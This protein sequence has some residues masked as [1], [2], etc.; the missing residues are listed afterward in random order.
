M[1]L[2]LDFHTR[3]PAPILGCFKAQGVA[4]IARYYDGGR[5]PGKG[6]TYA[7]AQDA[8]AVGL[9]IHTVYETSG[10]ADIDGFPFGGDYF[11][12]SQGWRD[13]L[14]AVVDANSARQ[15]RGTPIFLAVD[16]HMPVDDGR[17]T[18]YFQGATDSDNHIG[19]SGFLIG[20][21]GPDYVCIHVRDTFGI[22]NLWPWL[23]RPPHL[24]DLDYVLWQ[25]VNGQ[26]MCGAKV[27]LNDCQVEG[28][29]LEGEEVTDDEFLEKLHRLYTPGLQKQLEETVYAPLDGLT[30]A[31]E[32]HSH[33]T[34]APKPQL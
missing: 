31:H 6:L 13:W 21:Y 34:T 8:A 11:S 3:K 17:L 24:P 1:S 18:A 9:R 33:D 16:R 10:G 20:C 4:G 26:E 12:Y 14:E 29:T 15:P 22:Q 2:Y 23:P 19:G 25:Q 32:K 27:D 28:W 7:E 30:R 5:V